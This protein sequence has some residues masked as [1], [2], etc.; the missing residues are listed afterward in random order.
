MNPL[1][2]YSN[3]YFVHYPWRPEGHIK[4]QI[5]TPQQVILGEMVYSSSTHCVLI[6]QIKW[7]NEYASLQDVLEIF[8]QYAHQ[9]S[10]EQNT[11]GKLELKVKNFEIFRALYKLGFQ[12]KAEFGPT[13][14]NYIALYMKYEM[15]IAQLKTKFATTYVAENLGK[16]ISPYLKNEKVPT[17]NRLIICSTTH[18][19]G[20]TAKGGDSFGSFGQKSREQLKEFYQLEY[21]LHFLRELILQNSSYL[22]LR[23]N[24]I[25]N[26]G[27]KNISFNEIVQYGI[28]EPNDAQLAALLLSQQSD[29]ALK[30]SL[31]N[32][33]ED[34]N[35]SMLLCLSPQGLELMHNTTLS[36][37]EAVDNARP[38][39]PKIRQ[40]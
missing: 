31:G 9:K 5:K 34:L 4:V 19:L 8:L 25:K 17:Q 27:K 13:F 30:A 16:L 35:G 12:Q 20:L 10:I 7:S 39:M 33:W 6:H 18:R 2:P 15:R 29:D 26:L 24:A 21:K 37:H 32:R 36:N 28:L 23:D 22:L 38:T 1:I 3:C 11:E 40:F 14:A